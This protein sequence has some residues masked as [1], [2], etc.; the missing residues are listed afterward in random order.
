MHPMQAYVKRMTKSRP[1][2]KAVGG[3]LAPGILFAQ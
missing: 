2:A 1:L 3:A